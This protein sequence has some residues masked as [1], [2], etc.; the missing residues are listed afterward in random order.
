M[1]SW[2]IKQSIPAESD[3]NALG[4]TSSTVD[5]ATAEEKM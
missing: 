4:T 5:G 2:H 1:I 3:I